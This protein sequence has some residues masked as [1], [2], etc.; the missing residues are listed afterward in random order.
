[1]ERLAEKINGFEQQRE[2]LIADLTQ[3]RAE[4]AEALADP[5]AEPCDDPRAL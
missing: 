5:Q 2:V 3:I 1:M 4:L